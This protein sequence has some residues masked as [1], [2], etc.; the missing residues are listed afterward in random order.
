MATKLI[1]SPKPTPDIK[2]TP[3]PTGLSV[4][5]EALFAGVKFV[6][7][8]VGCVDDTKPV[9]HMVTG[10]VVTIVGDAALS[11][12]EVAAS[13]AKQAQLLV[14]D[15]ATTSRESQ[16]D[17]RNKLGYYTPASCDWS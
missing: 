17:P 2:G 6:Q 8:I 15:K 10:A 3:I 9:Q 7:T 14:V 5:D 13:L 4:T 12:S 16:T 11:V 1:A